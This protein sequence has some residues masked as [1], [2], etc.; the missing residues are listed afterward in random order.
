MRLECDQLKTKVLDQTNKEIILE[1]KHSKNEIEE[2]KQSFKILKICHEEEQA[3]NAK[4][5]C[6][7]NMKMSSLKLIKLAS[8]TTFLF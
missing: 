3:A 5:K 2:L 8:K 6:G 4:S 1:I 7:I